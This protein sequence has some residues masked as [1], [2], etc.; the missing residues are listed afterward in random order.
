MVWI[1]RC[2]RCWGL[3]GVSQ[4]LSF[5]ALGA[6]VG[7]IG[8]AQAQQQVHQ[9]GGAWQLSAGWQD[10]SEPKMQLKGPELGV[11]WQS[12]SEGPYT[13]EADAH[14]AV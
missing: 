1:F 7:T 6:L 12:L 9:T 8:S 3:F 4:T 2:F 5:C 10:Y 11:H 14:L 13:L